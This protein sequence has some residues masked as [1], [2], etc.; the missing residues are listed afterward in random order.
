[1]L[2]NQEIF[3]KALFGIRGQ[4]YQRSVSDFGCA[5][6]GH[7]GL[8]CA[9]G[10][11]IDDETAMLWDEKFKYHNGLDYIYMVDFG[12]FKKHFEPYQINLLAFLQ[13]AHDCI[14]RDSVKDFETNMK[15]IAQMFGLVYT[16][17]EPEATE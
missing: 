12:T 11:C 13:T 17:P 10:H 6:R 16:A 7:N 2:T 5:Y 1:M 4:G 8:K 15:H 9:V 14:L 3:D